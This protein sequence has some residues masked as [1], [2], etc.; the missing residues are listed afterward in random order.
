MLDERDRMPKGAHCQSQ[1]TSAAQDERRR[2]GYPDVGYLDAQRDQM[3]R[4]DVQCRTPNAMLGPSVKPTQ[5]WTVYSGQQPA[6]D[7]PRAS[8]DGSDRAAPALRAGTSKALGA[9]G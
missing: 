5:T 4:Q 6:A 1:E 9:R 7:V 2:Q 8:R 3:E